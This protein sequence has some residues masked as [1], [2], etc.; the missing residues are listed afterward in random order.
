MGESEERARAPS[1]SSPRLEQ[2]PRAGWLASVAR[3]AASVLASDGAGG[4]PAASAIA[5]EGYEADGM[6]QLSARARAIMTREVVRE[7]GW[8]FLDNK[9][10]DAALMNE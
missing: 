1:P 8:W 2:T 4:R 3:R 10:K 6:G 9:K 5:K 7:S